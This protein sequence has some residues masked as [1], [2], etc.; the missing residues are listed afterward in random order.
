MKK[1][2]HVVFLFSFLVI[3][4]CAGPS[5]GLKFLEEP[6][7]G[8]VVIIG[9]VVIENIN[10]EFAFDNWDYS[11]QVVIMG[12]TADGTLNHYT[13][14]TDDQGYYCLPN[15]P[16]GRYALKAAI[17]PVPG[18]IPLKLVNDLASRDSEFYRMRHPERPIDYTA[19]WLPPRVDGRIINLGIIWLGLRTPQ[20]SDLST[21]SIGIV[22]MSKFSESIKTK[23][24]WDYGYPYTREDPLTYFKKKFPDSG[25]WK[26]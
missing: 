23:R 11:S 6:K 26:L 17:L 16:A 9:N 15:V 7:E 25:W 13:V 1:I 10:Q 5:G 20:V 19:K 24:F 2:A 21:K 18:G 14:S 4:E 12:R 3:I 8:N 22:V